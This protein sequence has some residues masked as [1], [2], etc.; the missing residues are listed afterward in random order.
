MEKC[1]NYRHRN[2][3]AGKI[4]DTYSSRGLAI[5]H[6]VQQVIQ[7]SDLEKILSLIWVSYER[8]IYETKSKIIEH[9]N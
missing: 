1:V 6:V 8:T 4:R 2:M 7:K 5:H 9:K 3:R